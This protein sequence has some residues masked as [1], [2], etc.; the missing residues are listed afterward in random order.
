MF[1]QIKNVLRRGSKNNTDSVIHVD[2][3]RHTERMLQAVVDAIVNGLGFRAAM[4]AIVEE[5]SDS[6]GN[7]V[8]VLAVR[9]FATDLK[10]IPGGDQTLLL[11]GE[12]L[13]GQKLIGN[14]IAINEKNEHINQAVRAISHN[15]SHVVV[16][17]L[18]DLFAP[19]LDENICSL[20]QKTAGL[21]SFV[22]VPFRNNDGQLIGNLY[23][24]HTSTEIPASMIRQLKAFTTMASTALDNA[25]LYRSNLRTTGREAILK[26]TITQL[27]TV[28][29]DTQRLLD[30]I[31]KSVVDIM[32][33]R[34]CMVA[35]VEQKNNKPTLRVVSYQFTPGLQ[36]LLTWGER[37]TGL[38]LSGQYLY[39]DESTA[40]NNLAVR[41]VLNDLPHA[42]TK[43]LSELFSP[44]LP[45]VL[46]NQFQNQFGFK[47]LVTV[48]LR[49]REGQ[50]RGNMYAGSGAE[51]TENEIAELKT[52]VLAA[53]IA[54][55]NA[56]Q[57]RKTE[58]LYRES[59]R[60]GLMA[61]NFGNAAHRINN[62][63]GN[64]RLTLERE[65]QKSETNLTEK[66][67]VRLNDVKD[68]VI[69]SLALIKELNERVKGG[70]EQ[71]INIA[72]V[73]KEAMNSL[74]S[75][76]FGYQVVGIKTV[77]KINGDD[78]IVLATVELGE[79]F[80]VIMKNACEAMGDKG[81]LTV[82]ASHSVVED[83]NQPV[84]KVKISDTGP[85]IPLEN[86]ENLFEL[87]A[88][89]TKSGGMGYGIWGAYLTVQ[90]Y[91]GS[92]HYET[93]TQD[94]I[95]NN[96]DMKDQNPGTT[97]IILLPLTLQHNQ[98][99]TPD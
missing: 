5:Q 97:A 46:S 96:S 16:Y 21:K 30:D 58:Y 4:I 69:S 13:T 39:I 76:Q 32:G 72:D 91:G 14:S 36:G 75:G 59:R 55:D 15:E 60:M 26:T 49:N 50:L 63:L 8:S 40:K 47:E 17:K 18:Y 92:I 42:S 41:A 77:M 73:L 89:S 65:L 88:N 93:R 31:A 23:A 6:S 87:K 57:Y 11:W 37:M 84:V 48:P 43:K 35:I 12:N 56:N 80:R 9:G 85:G 45:D 78:L 53:S 99:G 54:I 24:G 28:T 70:D 51:I 10:L 74:K 66:Q 44:I 27:L 83:T 64:A 68:Q 2:V 67:L 98:F 34:A 94:E 33:F 7:L 81:T 1:K 79:I 62:M 22:T 29:L 71:P 20:I 25:Y 19:V 82:E 52:F 38:S 95:N 90:W 3:D 61:S 86:R